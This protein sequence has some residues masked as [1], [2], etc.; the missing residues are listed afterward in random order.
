MHYGILAI[1]RYSRWCSE[2][3]KMPVFASRRHHKGRLTMDL[4]TL[5]TIGDP[6]EVCFSG[7]EDGIATVLDVFPYT[8]RY[9]DWFTHVVRFSAENTSRGWMEITVNVDQER[10]ESIAT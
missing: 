10:K 6:I 4:K 8:G 3:G 1:E 2:S 9:P 7:R 5:P